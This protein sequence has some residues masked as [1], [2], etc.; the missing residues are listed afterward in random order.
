M[1]KNR[2][3][4]A[5]SA[6]GAMLSFGPALA[7]DMPVK[8][9]APAPAFIDWSGAYIGVHAGYGGG[10]KD[11]SSP[12]ADFVARGFLGGGQIG[13]NK[14]I[15][16]FVFGL[17]LDGS[18][19][20]IKGSQSISLGGPIAGIQANLAVA[21]KI[22]G[23]V[24]FTGRAGLAA[25]RWF[26]FAK[27][28]IAVAH[29]DHSLAI[30]QFFIPA[31]PGG[32]QSLT[33]SGNE[34]RVLP[35]LGFGAEYALGGNWSIKGEYDYFHSGSRN[36]RF[37]GSQTL[38]A[39]TTPVA[40]DL[41]IEQ[42]LHVVKLGV[43]YRFGGIAV[44]PAY[45]PV[46][47][48]PG[49]N[50]T[51][52]YIGVQGAY[53][54]GHKQWPDF[55]DPLNS[56]RGKYDVDGWLA[57]GTGG[58]N[59]QSGVFV[60]GVEGEWMRTGIKGGQTF[61]DAFLGLSQTTTLETSIDWLAIA[62]ARAGFVVGDKLLLYG[63]GGLAIAEEKQSATVTQTI[64]GVGSAAFALN[65]KPVHTGVVV[66]AGAEYA[67]GGNWSAK[68][69]YDYIRMF[70]QAFTGTGIETVNAPPAVGQ[71]DFAQK[72]DKM[73]QDMHLFKFGVNYH[74]NPMPVVVSARY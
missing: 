31:V 45:T 43:N 34:T 1:D 8:A 63:K 18:W 56:G 73:S 72:F 59:V 57:G 29:E 12:T 32:T 7:A 2:L 13:I 17:E 58:V 21:S 26:V 40:T 74:F 68:I 42:A 37:V 19:A 3:G 15:S 47:A 10:M 27:A 52:A 39:V 46:R 41:Q 49:Y 38:G 16:S 33:A 69:E 36:V 9:L 5:A 70:G 66:G 67:L 53:G 35:M 22:D 23:L 55:A 4:L 25:D 62:S 61:T 50:W 20:D 51:G 60:F 48:A 6:V 24:T 14:Q 11:Y 71:I 44:D 64:P 65:A 28:G 30:N 54:F